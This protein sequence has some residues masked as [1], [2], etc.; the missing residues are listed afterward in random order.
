[1]KTQG[2]AGFMA[3][4][5][6]AQAQA[7]IDTYASANAAYKSVVGIPLVGPTLAV[8]A[9]SAAISAGLLNVHQIEQTKYEAEEGLAI[10]DVF[11]NS[12][13]SNNSKGRKTDPKGSILRGA[14]HSGGGI[15]I[16]A[17][18][19]EIILTK[20]VY[21]D[22]E[23]RAIASEINVAGGGRKF[24]DGGV[25]GGG[26]STGGGSVLSGSLAPVLVEILHEIKALRMDLTEED[27]KS[28]NIIIETI[29]PEAR[30]KEYEGIKN[31]MIEAGNNGMG[32][33]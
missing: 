8:L 9:A 22:P 23:L 28:I 19:D 15:D 6:M 18:H 2:K 11:L 13:I 3:W 27:Q 10:N 33:P 30:V 7:L 5:R 17:E 32:N 12:I 4:K 21:R 24:A 1:M 20:G 16:N 14:S 26:S 29:D 25:A 31:N